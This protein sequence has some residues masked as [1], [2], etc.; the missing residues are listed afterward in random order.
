MK[1][2]QILPL[3]L[4]TFLCSTVYAGS[5]T[6]TWKALQSL[7]GTWE[8]VGEGGP[9]SGGGQFSFSS[10]LLDRII[11][12]KNHS[13]YP[14]SE[15]RPAIVHDDLLVAYQE[16]STR[17]V[18]AIYFDNE[19]H[20][21]NYAVDA[22]PDGK[23]VTFLSAPASSGPR[24]RQSYVRKDGEELV[25]RFEIAPPGKPDAFKMYLEGKA[26]RKK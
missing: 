15:G 11:V 8:G 25:L 12:R 13:E 2:H 9:G 10:D 22:S 7:V 21:I 14:A 17:G 16:D 26:R 5:P 3:V 23:T 1:L 18:R 4:I 19:G 6:D 24:Y 20:V